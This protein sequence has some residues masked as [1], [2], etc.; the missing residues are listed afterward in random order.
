MKAGDK[1]RVCRVP[2]EL[3]DNKIRTADVF[4]RCLG[5]IFPV[6]NVVDAEDRELLELE[7]GEVCGEEAYMQA[8]WRDP[9]FAELIE[10]SS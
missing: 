9:E 3:P 8:I 10:A 4:R 2:P 1:V 7:V 6:M 5:R